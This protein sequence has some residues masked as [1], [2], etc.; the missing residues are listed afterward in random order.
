MLIGKGDFANSWLDF[1][2]KAK[3]ITSKGGIFSFSIFEVFRHSLLNVLM[4]S[5]LTLTS[6]NY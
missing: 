1:L 2:R 3:T 4:L 6:Y 5:T